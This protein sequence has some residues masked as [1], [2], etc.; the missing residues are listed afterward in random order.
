MAIQRN[1]RL[2]SHL[3]RS[4]QLVS[5]A[6]LAGNGALNLFLGGVDQHV[7]AV[8]VKN[9]VRT[10]VVVAHAGRYIHQVRQAQRAGQNRGMGG[11]ATVQ[12]DNTNHFRTIQGDY[13]RRRD[14]FEADNGVVW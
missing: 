13:F 9:N 6:F 14:V 12:S 3:Q 1:R 4:G 8:G 10:V 7:A 2:V 5:S 11:G